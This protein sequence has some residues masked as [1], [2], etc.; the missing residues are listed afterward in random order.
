MNQLL[1]ELNKNQLNKY[2]I[3]FKNK[4]EY[5]KL[6]KEE[7]FNMARTMFKSYMKK[8][9]SMPKIGKSTKGYWISRGW[10]EEEIDE[11][12]EKRKNQNSPMKKEFWLEKGYSEKE[13]TSDLINQ[14]A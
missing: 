14:H 8:T 2:L 3:D 7:D 4:E 6:F 5:L 12:I 1:I 10:I 9:I 13:S 11:K